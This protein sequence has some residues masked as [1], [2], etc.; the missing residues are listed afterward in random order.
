MNQNLA[1]NILSLTQFLATMLISVRAF[2]LY[3]Q[4]RSSRL[5]TLG[6]SMSI[7]TL[8]TVASF[9]DDNAIVVPTN[10]DWFKYSGQTVGFLFICLSLVHNSEPYLH[11]LR[12]WQIIF[13]ALLLLLLTPLVPHAFPDPALTKTLLGGSRCLI[14]YI[15]FYF[16]VIAF[17][18]K[19]T[20]FSLLMSLTFLLLSFGYLLNVPKYSMPGMT[21]LDN[22]GDYTRISGLVVLL[23]AM[24]L[25]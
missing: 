20:R 3:G 4:T 10:L 21:L 8:T 5:F 15:I 11:R 19:E 9:I 12:N 13:S 17:S 25:A 18:S 6:L 1:A 14:C 2:W 24:L 7:I 16:Y 22:V 23:I